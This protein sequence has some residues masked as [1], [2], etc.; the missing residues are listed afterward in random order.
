MQ[1]NVYLRF[2]F[3]A[4]LFNDSKT[5]VDM[6]LKA[7]PEV[8]LDVFSR[9]PPNV[10]QEQL[11]EFVDTYFHPAGSDIIPYYPSDW[12]RYPPFLD[13]TFSDVNII[14]TFLV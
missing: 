10:T 8:V 14:S 5:F 13:G 6:P 4:L 11:R 12:K 9:L 7:P 2:I 1:H 3:R